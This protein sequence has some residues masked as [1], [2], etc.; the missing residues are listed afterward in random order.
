VLPRIENRDEYF[1]EFL[2]SNVWDKAIEFI[3]RKHLLSGTP[4]RADLGSNIVYRVGGHWIK[5]FAPI[6]QDEF[7]IEIAGLETASSINEFSVPRLFAAGLVDSWP[8]MIISHV[9]GVRIG[10]RW[11]ALA[12]EQKVRLASQFAVVTRVIQKLKPPEIIRKRFD[13][14]VFI[15]DRFSLAL[16]TQVT[17]GLS[18][19]SVRKLVFFLS[20]F[21]VDQFMCAEPVYL[22]ADLT[23]DHFLIDE[24]GN[25][26]Q[27]V[28]DFTD[29]MIGHPEYDLAAYFCYLLQRRKEAQLEFYKKWGY[30]LEPTRIL[31]WIVLHLFSDLNRYFGTGAFDRYSDL[32]DFARDVFA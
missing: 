10:D 21:S 5:L 30:S 14:N 8:Y 27:G 23:H 29:S 20:Q 2:N 12:S 4:M 25:H 1:K 32:T 3:T 17:K 19:T 31:M 15:T 9:E 28:I 11:D 13:W 7:E 26:I 16:S 18:T 24:T 6:F 22:H